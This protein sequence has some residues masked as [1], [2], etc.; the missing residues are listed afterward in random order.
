MRFYYNKSIPGFLRSAR[1]NDIWF[2]SAKVITVEEQTLHINF[3]CIFS[4]QIKVMCFNM[5]GSLMYP[6]HTAQILKQERKG[7]R[8]KQH[9]V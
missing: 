3:P 6:R 7:S 9:T 1:C 2:P 5:P 4:N 8:S